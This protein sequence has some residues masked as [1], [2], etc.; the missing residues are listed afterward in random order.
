MQEIAN[1]RTVLTPRDPA[2]IV[3]MLKPEGMAAA[4][5][6]RGYRLALRW[7]EAAP[8]VRTKKWKTCS[9]ARVVESMRD[10]TGHQV[11]VEEMAMALAVS[12]FAARVIDGEPSTNCKLRYLPKAGTR[13]SL[14]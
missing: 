7:I 3:A 11:T 6:T 8:L 13:V 5:H 2:G 12:G 9:I 10:S 4:V 14:D 1:S